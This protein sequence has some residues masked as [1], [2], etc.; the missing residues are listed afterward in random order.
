LIRK[1]LPSA[2]GIEIE[3]DWRVLSRL[4]K[5]KH[6]IKKIDPFGRAKASA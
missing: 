2:K 1:E 4:F 5:K 3:N 6:K